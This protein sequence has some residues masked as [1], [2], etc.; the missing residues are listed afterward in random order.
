MLGGQS[1]RRY[2]NFSRDLCPICYATALSQDN[3]GL[4]VKLIVLSLVAVYLVYFTIPNGYYHFLG[5]GGFAVAI[6]WLP[7]MF[8]FRTI[9]KAKKRSAQLRLVGS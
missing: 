3:A 8:K 2:A 9:Q 5:L 7:M 4:R 1:N 6:T